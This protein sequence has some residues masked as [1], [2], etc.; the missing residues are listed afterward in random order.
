MSGL[1]TDPSSPVMSLTL[2][3]TSL[4]ITA[5]KIQQSLPEMKRNGNTVLSAISSEQLYDE[6]STP[7]A[8]SVLNQAEF[9]PGLIQ[10]LQDEPNK[11]IEA[12]EV[13]RRT[14]ESDCIL[15]KLFIDKPVIPQ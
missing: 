2:R 8:G 4:Q 3:L 1:Q 9:I 10:Q 12:F 7:R 14:G 6:T 11:V 5:A 13:I 15:T